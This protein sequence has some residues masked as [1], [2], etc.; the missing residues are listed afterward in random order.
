M[1]CRW[2]E[3]ER[4]LRGRSAVSSTESVV[5]LV[6]SASRLAFERCIQPITSDEDFVTRR[7]QVANVLVK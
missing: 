5:L 4:R 7:H 6:L 1:Q 2:R 3:Y